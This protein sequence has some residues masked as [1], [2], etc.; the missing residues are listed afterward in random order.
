MVLAVTAEGDE[1]EQGCSHS[2]HARQADVD[3]DVSEEEEV[4]LV[5]ERGGVQLVA[6]KPPTKSLYMTGQFCTFLLF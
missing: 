4:Q 6:E 5:A 3:G 1:E 2:C